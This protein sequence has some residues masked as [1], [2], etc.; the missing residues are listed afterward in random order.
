MWVSEDEVVHGYL[1]CGSEHDLAHYC[2]S[3]LSFEKNINGHV[4]M[5]F[6]LYLF[7]T[8]LKGEAVMQVSILYSFFKRP[9]IL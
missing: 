7:Y 6:L 1:Q 3:Y 2:T 5:K 8:I 4:Q 9:A